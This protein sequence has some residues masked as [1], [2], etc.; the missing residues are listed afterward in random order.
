MLAITLLLAAIFSF[1]PLLC[2]W[3]GFDYDTGDYVEID[4]QE[5]VNPGDQI[6]IYDYADQ[7]YHEVEI[8]SVNRLANPEIEAYDY[9]ADEYR[10][11][12]MEGVTIGKKSA[13]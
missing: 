13:S 2:A 7:T 4:D 6:V 1:P 11:F 5:P 8:I 10:T 9:D 12:E 3:D